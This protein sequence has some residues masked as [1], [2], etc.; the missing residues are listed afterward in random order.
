MDNLTIGF[1]VAIPSIFFVLL[2]VLIVKKRKLKSDFEKILREAEQYQ[3]T[4]MP[5]CDLPDDDDLAERPGQ[6]E[7][8]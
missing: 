4:Q 5:C 2:I 7:C 8:G 6:T 1:A 3:A